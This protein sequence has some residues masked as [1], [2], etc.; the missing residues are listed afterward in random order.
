[1]DRSELQRKCGTALKAHKIILMFIVV[2][3]VGVTSAISFQV[4]DLAAAL[5]IFSIVFGAI[6]TILLLLM[7]AEE[8]TFLG[9]ARIATALAHTREGCALFRSALASAHP[10]KSH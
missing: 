2:A 5:L 6:G 7:L 3:A 9:I 1:M 10:P 4:R 8:V